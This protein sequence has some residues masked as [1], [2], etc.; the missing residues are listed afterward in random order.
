MPET[1]EIQDSMSEPANEPKASQERD[2]AGV[3]APPPVIYLPALVVA[4]VL[5]AVWPLEFI[6][7]PVRY[8][9]G[10]GLVLLGILITP[11]VLREFARARTSFNALRPSTAVIRSGP[12]RYS[13]NP[14]YVALTVT[15]IGLGIVL[16]NLWVLL[17][18]IPAVLLVHFGVVLREE[19]YL[20]RRFGEKYRRYKKSVR[21]WL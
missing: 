1:L 11:F 10:G 7:G 8:L 2:T 13:R 12:F 19:R 14:S 3:L 18:L 20:E 16:D 4:L 6:G 9:L 17:W 15:W 21:R 5:D